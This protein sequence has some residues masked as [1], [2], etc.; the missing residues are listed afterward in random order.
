MGNR[1]QESCAPSPGFGEGLSLPPLV[2]EGSGCSVA[3]DSVSLLSLPE[4]EF[5]LVSP[6]YLLLCAHITTL[7]D[8]C[9]SQMTVC[10]S[11]LSLSAM[12]DPGETWLAGLGGKLSHLL[13][14]VTGPSPFI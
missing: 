6:M 3:C 10:G 12:C 5:Y 1:C 11:H 2:C 14:H 13:S 7:V 8:M 9:R 4:S